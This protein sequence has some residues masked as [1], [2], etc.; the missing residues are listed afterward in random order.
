VVLGWTL[1]VSLIGTGREF[2]RFVML[3]RTLLILMALSTLTDRVCGDGTATKFWL[4][5]SATSPIGPESPQLDVALG[6]TTELFIWYRP[7]TLTNLRNFS[8]NVV[9]DQTGIDLVD[10]TFAIRNVASLGVDRFEFV[11]DSSYI[12]PLVSEF[13]EADVVAGDADS[14]LNLQGFTLFP[15][16]SVVGIGPLCDRGELNCVTATDGQPA[17]LLASFSIKGVTAGAIVDVHLQIGDFGMNQLLYS[18]GDYDFDG[19]VGTP[20]YDVWR[21]SFG[22]TTSSAADG[23]GNGNVEAA[24]Y[25]IWRDRFGA[26]SILQPTSEVLVQFGSDRTPATPQETYD[27]LNDRSLTLAGDDPDAVIHVGGPGAGMGQAMTPEPSTAFLLLF[28][29]LFWAV[30]R[31]PKR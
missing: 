25:I 21:E 19:L 15:S 3:Q 10:G 20:D 14:I 13:T 8:L 4:S 12:P 31:S 29:V 7:M 22:S 23:N 30:H 27:A 17:W 5:T 28:A 1:Q 2:W 6:S 24:D 16:A 9:C 18:P 26:S 11:T